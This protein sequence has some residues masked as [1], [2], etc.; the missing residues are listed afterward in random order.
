MGV[1]LYGRIFDGEGGL[2][3][4]TCW[5]AAA[6]DQTR[7]RKGHEGPRNHLI[8]FAIS[9]H[10]DDSCLCGSI[11]TRIEQRLC[12]QLACTYGDHASACTA[13]LL[14][15][16]EGSRTLLADPR[17]DIRYPGCHLCSR[18]SRVLDLVRIV[19]I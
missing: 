10:S 2:I 11:D 17:D 9:D 6:G 16:S 1:H 19:H 8:T 12:L 13:R 14:D 3:D 7:R 15:A 18:I 4:G 5:Q